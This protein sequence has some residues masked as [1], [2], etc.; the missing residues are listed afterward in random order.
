MDWIDSVGS[1]RPNQKP[2]KHEPL[3]Y[4]TAYGSVCN[5]IAVPPHTE[6]PTM[7]VKEVMTPANTAK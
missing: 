7:A 3:L 6:G 4:N 1:L 5:Q 2:R